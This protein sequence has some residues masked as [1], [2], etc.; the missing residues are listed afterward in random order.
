MG[1]AA[2]CMHLLIP[3]SG[4]GR[5]YNY[6]LIFVFRIIEIYFKKPILAF[7]THFRFVKMA[8]VLLEMCVREMVFFFL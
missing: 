3:L 7:P 1:G 4:S 6:A 2:G 5:M 8:A